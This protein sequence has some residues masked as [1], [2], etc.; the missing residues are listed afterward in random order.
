MRNYFCHHDEIISADVT[1]FILMIVLGK[2]TEEL[3]RFQEEHIC[4][5]VLRIARIFPPIHNRCKKLKASL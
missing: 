3:K 2:M 5:I 4:N 1:K